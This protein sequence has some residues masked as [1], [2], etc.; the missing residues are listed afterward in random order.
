VNTEGPAHPLAD[1]W[2]A[3]VHRSEH[4]FEPIGAAVLV[5]EDRLLTCAH[6][7]MS[8]GVVREPLWIAF[9][10][11]DCPRRRVGSVAVAY[12]L[13]VRDLAVLVLQEPVSAGVQPAPLRCGARKVRT[14]SAA[15][16]GR[17]VFLIEIRSAIRPMG[18]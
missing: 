18:R 14:L 5:D 4:D 12:S 9:P 1:T 13:P 7:V 16:G 2:V 10:K 15:R 8:D 6:V 11:A 17:S 3:A